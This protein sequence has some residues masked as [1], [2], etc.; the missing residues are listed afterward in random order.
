MTSLNLILH[1]CDTRKF[2]IMAILHGKQGLLWDK[3]TFSPFPLIFSKG[4]S[5][6]GLCG[7]RFILYHIMLNLAT[8]K[9]K[10]FENIVGKGENVGN[11]HFLLFPQCFLHSKKKFQFFIYIYLVVCKCFQFGAV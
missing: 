2:V 6:K 3:P 8:L 4:L 7:M 9:E 10:A 5:Q 1:V 11:Q